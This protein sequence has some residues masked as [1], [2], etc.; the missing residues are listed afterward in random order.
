MADLAAGVISRILRLADKS[1]DAGGLPFDVPVDIIPA[2]AS[3]DDDDG[4]ADGFI[5]ASVRPGTIFLI[6]DNGHPLLTR[7]RRGMRARGICF[8]EYRLDAAHDRP[9]RQR[10]E[11]R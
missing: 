10:R 11:P 9:M 5:F 1:H 8:I 3:E 6:C 4:G 7:I 2:F